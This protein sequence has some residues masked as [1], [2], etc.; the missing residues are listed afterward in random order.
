M[1]KVLCFALLA[2]LFLPVPALLAEGTFD[3]Q[4]HGEDAG[5]ECAY[6]HSAGAGGLPQRALMPRQAVCLDCHEEAEIAGALPERPSSHAGDYE[7]LHQF[8]VRAGESDCMLCHRESESCTLCHAG[9]NVDFLAHDRN[10]IDNHPVVARKGI[11]NCASCHDLQS[12]CSDCHMQFGIQ[13]GN[14]FSHTWR[15]RT[16]HGRAAK[17][18]IGSCPV[19]WRPSIAFNFGFR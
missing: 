17:E 10:W 15:W 11:T 7:H 8:N 16:G 2:C 6:C 13:P 14:H 18:D 5:L 3:H 12:D 9:E 1:R 19:Y 4:I